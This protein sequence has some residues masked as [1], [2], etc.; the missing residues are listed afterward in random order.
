MKLREEVGLA[1][2]PAAAAGDEASASLLSPLPAAVSA[3]L[4]C[5]DAVCCPLSA[6][7]WMV[8]LS[9]LQASHCDVGLNARLKISALSAPLLTSWQRRSCGR[10]EDADE[11]AGL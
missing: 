11:R 5:C 1:F 9:E 8:P 3:P 7:M 2:L 4:T 10:V 6:K